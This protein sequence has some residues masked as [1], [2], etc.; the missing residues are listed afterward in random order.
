MKFN[1][2]VLK[3]VI[4][5]AVAS[6]SVL[7]LNLSVSASDWSNK[8]GF[9]NLKITEDYHHVFT[10]NQHCSTPQI[11]F[12]EVTG[13]NKRVRINVFGST[14]N[15]YYIDRNYDR[16]LDYASSCEFVAGGLSTG[17]YS[18]DIIGIKG[19]GNCKASGTFEMN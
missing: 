18:M 8:G 6:A 17:T 7:V 12:T 14:D 1:K 19:F 2:N 9:T 13:W 3:K 5:G 10:I 11:S 16:N 4:V 15:G